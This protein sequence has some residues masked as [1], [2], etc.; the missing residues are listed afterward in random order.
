MRCGG[1]GGRGPVQIEIERA[2]EIDIGIIGDFVCIALFHAAIGLAA[3]IGHALGNWC[4]EIVVGILIDR[5]GD[6]VI[7]ADQVSVIAAI[8]LAGR[9]IEIEL[10]IGYVFREADVDGPFGAC[11]RA[12]VRHRDIG[13]HDAA[14][15]VGIGRRR[16]VAT[17]PA[18][19][20]FARG[21]MPG[22]GIG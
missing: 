13:E 21:R 7:F 20:G 19:A 18:T 4:V 5:N 1:P 6:L 2:G 3:P 10:I 15:G 8:N 12:S 17:I 14:G 22:C 9:P 16:G 11:R